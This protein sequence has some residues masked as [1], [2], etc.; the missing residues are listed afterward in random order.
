VMP[1]P[2]NGQMTLNFEHMTGKID[3]KVYDMRGVLIDQLQTFGTTE[4]H[5]LS[6]QCD[7]KGDGI[8]CFVATSKEGTLVRK[9]V[10]VH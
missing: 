2:N 3:I 1:N 7:T 6:Y 10:I 8:Y 5:N 9:V 4:R